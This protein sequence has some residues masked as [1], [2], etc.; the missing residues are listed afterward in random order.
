[1]LEVRRSRDRGYSDNGWLK[2]FHSFAFAD[3]FDPEHVEFGPLR[4]I[5]EDRVRPGKS[6]GPHSPQ[7]MEILTFVVRGEIER[8]NSLGATTVLRAGDVQRLSAGT[9]IQ[10]SETNLSASEEAYLLQIWIRPA[11]LGLPPSCETRHFK[12]EDK[13]GRLKLIA[14]GSGEAGALKIQQDTRVYA[15]TLG[16]SQSVQFEVGRGRCAYI[17]VA[18]GSVAV[19]ETRL[20]SGDAMKITQAPRIILQNGTDAEVILMNLPANKL[21]AVFHRPR[22]RYP[23]PHQAAK[24]A[25]TPPGQTAQSA[26]KP[27]A[28][29]LT[30]SLAAA[31]TQAGLARGAAADAAD[32]ATAAVTTVAAKSSKRAAHRKIRK[33][34]AAGKTKARSQKP[35]RR[36]GGKPK[37][38][39]P[40]RLLARRLK[41]RSAGLSA[42]SG[43]RVA[44]RKATSGK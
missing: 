14:S 1:M 34:A 38:K 23:G 6:F 22:V 44:R 31:L 36:S 7:D 11:K 33:S 39:A 8:Q 41:P 24:A 28:P 35:A 18:H 17:H 42:G 13:A 25:L 21:N 43:R 26:T 16:S 27:D 15:L 3:Y 20:N 37:S 9:G 10:H 30:T 4:V 2:T 12:P 40:A 19:G 29:E 32:G 5:N